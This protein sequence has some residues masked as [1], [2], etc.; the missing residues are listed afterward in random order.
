M[1]KFLSISFSLLIL[2][3]VMHLTISTHYCDGVMAASKVSVLG[4]LASCG[5]ETPVDKCPSTGSHFGSNCCSNKVSV[6]AVAN[7]YTP[8]FSEFKSF[9]QP[10]LQVFDIPLSYQIQSLSV[11]NLYSTNVSPPGN[12]MVSAVSLPDICV[13]RI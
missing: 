9:S 2:I 8:S 11:L 1:K 12:F 5:M 13:F 6:F 4:E 3:S 7:N 10:V